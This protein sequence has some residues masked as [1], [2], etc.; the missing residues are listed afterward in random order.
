M[1]SV[2]RKKALLDQLLHEEITKAVLSLIAEDQTVTMEMVAKRCGVA[3]GTLY[4]YFR[5]KDDLL[6]V[7]NESVLGEIVA[8]NNVVWQ[9]SAP[10]LERL[11]NFVD[12]VYRTFD[13]YAVYFR[14]I[15]R[16]KSADEMLEKRDQLI[17]S[18]LE[19]ILVEGISRGEFVASDPF[20]LAEMLHG[21]IIGALEG[22]AYRETGERDMEQMKQNV[23][24]LISKVISV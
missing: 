16:G 2:G 24:M 4:N 14:F 7:V 21:A 13:K 15:R 9:S 1:A 22:L 23:K 18:P 20:I 12:H 19:K 8:G 10:P 5:N 11:M 6:Q 3:K 17:I